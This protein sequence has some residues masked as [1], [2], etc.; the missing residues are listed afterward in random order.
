MPA[1]TVKPGDE[2]ARTRSACCM[3]ARFVEP[4]G[5]RQRLGMVGDGDVLEPTLASRGDHGLQVVAAVRLGRMHVQVA[6]KLSALDQCRQLPFDGGFNFAP[7]LTQLRRH[8][9]EAKGFVDAVLGLARDRLVVGRVEEPV[10]VQ[11]PSARERAIAKDDVVRLGAGEV[12]E[13]SAFLVRSNQ[14]EVH[15]IAA[16]QQQARLRLALSR[17]RV[18]REGSL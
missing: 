17:G 4:V 10:L 15:L 7:I 18:R 13:R 16:A 11:P 8:P 9:G 1:S 14:P 2:H 12:L 5:H 3:R 6:T